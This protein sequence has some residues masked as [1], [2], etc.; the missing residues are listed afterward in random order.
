M[1]D[2]ICS[3]EQRKQSTK[4]RDDVSNG[5]WVL[6]FKQ[7]ELSPQFRLGEYI[8]EE[9]SS[10]DERREKEFLVTQFIYIHKDKAKIYS[11]TKLYVG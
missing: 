7:K 1:F 5:S 4:E 9:V 2:I 3:C 8:C 6:V 11:L 10:T